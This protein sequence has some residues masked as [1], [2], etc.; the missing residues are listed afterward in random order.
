MLLDVLLLEP[1][2]SGDA[3]SPDLKES[4]LP[5]GDEI[6]SKKSDLPSPGREMP[7]GMLVE[8]RRPLKPSDSNGSSTTGPRGDPNLCKA[9]PR[10]TGVQGMS[11]F[12]ARGRPVTRLATAIVL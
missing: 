4:R 7:T 9:P 12:F 3:L 1:S 6:Y 11:P 2:L 5:C 8:L 10:G